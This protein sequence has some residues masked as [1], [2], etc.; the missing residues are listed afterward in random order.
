MNIAKAV[1]IPKY[2][3]GKKLEKIRIENPAIIVNEVFC[4]ALPTVF[5]QRVIVSK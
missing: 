1:N 5:W 2:I 3:V 4:I